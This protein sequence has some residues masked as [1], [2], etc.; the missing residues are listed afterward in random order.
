MTTTLFLFIFDN[1]A[2]FL[3]LKTVVFLTVALSAG[4]LLFLLYFH[5]SQK[6]LKK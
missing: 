5:V 3:S 6:A 1:L 4:L 2:L